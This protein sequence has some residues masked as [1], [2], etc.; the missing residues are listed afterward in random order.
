MDGVII[1]GDS[2]PCGAACD[3]IAF[4]KTLARLVLEEQI[5]AHAIS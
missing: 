3:A 1:A 5:P 2:R 4:N